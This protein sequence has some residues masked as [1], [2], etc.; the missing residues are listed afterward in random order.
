[1]KKLPSSSSRDLI[2]VALFLAALP[3]C[4]QRAA[5][6]D[7]LGSGNDCRP[8]LSLT[9]LDGAALGDE[10]LRGQVTLVNFWATWCAPCAKEIPA[11]QAVYERHRAQGFT[12]IG[13]VTGDE[14]TDDNVKAFA[15]GRKV[16]YPLVRGVP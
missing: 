13:M 16:S 3:A 8:P 14:A 9:T 5:H 11:L 1:M 12:V 10:A 2:L 6:A 15:A 4:T 7:C